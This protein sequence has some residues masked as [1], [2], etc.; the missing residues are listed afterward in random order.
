MMVVR[1]CSSY[2][3]RS[4]ILVEFVKKLAV[5]QEV[6]FTGLFYWNRVVS[7]LILFI[8]VGRTSSNTV[9]GRFHVFKK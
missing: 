2:V 9:I 4:Y 1:R 6:Q 7:F 8:F 3:L 5:A